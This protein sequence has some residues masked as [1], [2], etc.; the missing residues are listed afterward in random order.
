MEGGLKLVEELQGRLQVLLQSGSKNVGVRNGISSTLVELRNACKGIGE[1]EVL[2]DRLVEVGDDLWEHGCRFEAISSVYDLALELL[3]KNRVSIERELRLRL[4]CVQECRGIV[5]VRRA[6]KLLK[7]FAT[8]KNDSVRENMYFIV[9][10]LDVLMLSECA[11]LL[12]QGQSNLILQLLKNLILFT[13]SLL[14]LNQAKYMSLRQELCILFCRSWEQYGDLASAAQSIDDLE[15]RLRLLRLDESQQ[16]PIPAEVENVLINGEKLVKI[17]KVKYKLLLNSNEKALDCFK[18]ET[19]DTNQLW[20]DLEILLHLQGLHLFERSNLTLVDE[21]SIARLGEIS[22]EIRVNLLPEA[23]KQPWDSSSSVVALLFAKNG[24]WEA[25]SDIHK[26][27]PLNSRIKFLELVRKAFIL[28]SSSGEATRDLAKWMIAHQEK[29]PLV[30]DA[31]ILLW[32]KICKPILSKYLLSSIEEKN[33]LL[34]L[35]E[36]IHCS[37]ARNASAACICM[38]VEV[39]LRFS[40]V[41]SDLEQDSR[42]AI[43]ILRHAKLS[44]DVFL[45]E[46]LR[47]DP[48]FASSSSEIEK[49]KVLYIDLLICLFQ[50]ELSDAIDAEKRLVAEFKR[51]K[52]ALALLH[53]ITASKQPKEEFITMAK[54]FRKAESLLKSAESQR[55]RLKSETRMNIS[56]S[57]HCIRIEMNGEDG[58]HFRVF[59]KLAGATMSAVSKLDANLLN[60]GVLCERGEIV[61]GELDPNQLYALMIDDD[62]AVAV[63]ITVP[64]CAALSLVLCRA[65]V[66]RFLF[67]AVRPFLETSVV[68]LHHSVREQL[69]NCISLCSKACMEVMKNFLSR[70]EIQPVYSQDPWD[71]FSFKEKK[72]SISPPHLQAFVYAVLMNDSLDFKQASRLQNVNT[73]QAI[74]SLRNQK[75]LINS[76]VKLLRNSKLLVLALDA[77]Q[78][79]EDSV[80]IIQ[81]CERLFQKLVPLLRV[82]EG[83]V[84]TLR[85]LIAI[86]AALSSM[87]RDIWTKGTYELF[88]ICAFQVMRLQ[89]PSKFSLGLVASRPNLIRM[90]RSQE[91]EN[92][93]LERENF[94]TLAHINPSYHGKNQLETLQLIHE[95][96]QNPRQFLNPNEDP[97]SIG[98]DEEILFA[99]AHARVEN[100]FSAMEGAWKTIQREGMENHP[101]YLQLTS[102]LFREALAFAECPLQ[103]WIE[104]AEMLLVEKGDEKKDDWIEDV[105]LEEKSDPYQVL[106]SLKY[107]ATRE[108]DPF[109]FDRVQELDEERDNLKQIVASLSNEDETVEGLVD[110]KAKLESIERTLELIQRRKRLLANHGVRPPKE[111]VERLVT[112]SELDRLQAWR[113]YKG[114]D[115][116]NYACLYA[117]DN[118]ITL[119][120]P[121]EGRF[122]NGVLDEGP[123]TDLKWSRSQTSSTATLGP[124][125]V[126]RLFPK[127]LGSVPMEGEDVEAEESTAIENKFAANQE[128]ARTLMKQNAQALRIASRGL[129][130]ARWAHAWDQVEFCGKLLWNTLQLSWIAPSEFTDDGEAQEEEN[131]DAYDWKPIFRASCSILDM[132]EIRGEE[133]MN[134]I[135]G[136]FCDLKWAATFQIFM[137]QVFC[138][139]KRWWEILWLGERYI[140][141][142]GTISSV[143]QLFE[144]AIPLI[145]LASQNVFNDAS[146]DVESI[147]KRLDE[148]VDNW[149]KGF[150][151]K[152]RRRTTRLLRAP[153]HLPKEISQEE[154]AFIEKKLQLESEL[155]E[156]QARAF[157]T[158]EIVRKFKVIQGNLLRDRSVCEEALRKAQILARQALLEFLEPTEEGAPLRMLAEIPGLETKR[159]SLTQRSKRSPGSVASKSSKISRLSR[160]S[161][162]SQAMSIMTKQT[163]EEPDPDAEFGIQG[164]LAERALAQY[165]KAIEI[166]RQNQDRLFLSQALLEEGDFLCAQGGVAG[167]AKAVTSWNDGLDAILGNVNSIDH[168]RE[169]LPVP[170]I[171]KAPLGLEPGQEILEKLGVNGIILGTIHCA[172]LARFANLQ[173]F[174]L[175]LEHVR[176]AAWLLCGLATCTLPHPLKA[177][178]FADYEFKEL[179]RTVEYEILHSKMFQM[180]H[181]LTAMCE[182]GRLLTQ[183]FCEVDRLLALP[184]L[185]L[186]KY[187][188]EVVCRRSEIGKE[189]V[190][191]KALALIDLGLLTEASI[192]LEVGISYDASEMPQQELNMSFLESII[193]ADSCNNERKHCMARF[194][195]ESLE[196]NPSWRSGKLL[197]KMIYSLDG[198]NCNH[199]ICLLRGVILQGKAIQ[200]I[201]ISRSLLSF[202]NSVTASDMRERLFQWL[203]ARYLLAKYLTTLD[204]IEAALQQFEVLAEECDALQEFDL[205]RIALSNLAR[206]HEILGSKVRIKQKIMEEFDMLDENI[207]DLTSAQNSKDAAILVGHLEALSFFQKKTSPIPS[208]LPLMAAEACVRIEEYDKAQAILNHL[209]DE[210]MPWLIAT[211]KLGQ[212]TLQNNKTLLEEALDEAKR[213]KGGFGLDLAR[214]AAVHLAI[215]SKSE[216]E[217]VS[218]MSIAENIGMVYASRTS[219][220][221]ALASDPFG[222]NKI[223]IQT[224]NEIFEPR[225]LPRAAACVTEGDL[226][227]YV[228]KL[229]VTSRCTDT[230]D[231]N[232]ILQASEYLERKLPKFAEAFRLQETNSEKVCSLAV[233]WLE[234]RNNKFL[235]VIFDAEHRGVKTFEV[236]KDRLKDVKDVIESKLGTI[237]AA[238]SVFC[239]GKSEECVEQ[240]GEKNLDPIRNAFIAR[241]GACL[242]QVDAESFRKIVSHYY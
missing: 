64:T 231:R 221:V 158:E 87:D 86:E 43:K 128:E 19:L 85:P 216:Q 40:Q 22:E 155:D 46:T 68:H 206:L 31:A 17:W 49:V 55:L 105:L 62:N 232:F 45:S 167:W 54:L 235:M 190:A 233:Q 99:I 42:R 114:W 131:F 51:N 238:H 139:L 196:S 157:K 90:N 127:G 229:I 171:H 5:A 74:I 183:T 200:A 9:H 136:T 129:V 89:G 38:L 30:L 143:L 20:S 198:Q 225:F 3:P 4:K 220:M 144:P 187:F 201:E 44:M 208:L 176:L 184:V 164:D 69:E 170:K 236:A 13:D 97:D 175:Q 135:S 179:S 140:Q 58:K 152:Q 29:D 159:T 35:L 103:S 98:T 76:Q 109:G 26:V 95:K 72:I 63:S 163:L 1:A 125:P 50:F 71:Y 178:N 11:N 25:V 182:T 57:P 70:G 37:L 213:I 172:R 148:L 124:A 23:L 119:S 48:S 207:E 240:S 212:G 111:I 242:T 156:A 209:P 168:W 14:P 59:G 123:F 24:C 169:L 151:Q 94:Q 56:F 120:E 82:P 192:L 6:E 154:Q 41:L 214:Q 197:E 234:A 161:K 12:S 181:F 18:E 211:I 112:L 226:I 107:P 239:C 108:R 16:P 138:H 223:D 202:E 67:S 133:L 88:G 106:Q 153:A 189:M 73:K 104:R 191:Y 118:Q 219:K 224:A 116:V 193:G 162:R 149:N 130:R 146:K 186:C 150:L 113:I 230:D 21:S 222:Q 102:L 2:F 117:A 7:R 60:T 28:S 10:D 147:K 92:D 227:L 66:Q 204:Q 195:L 188:A 32:R 177:C 47:K 166:L 80:L 132:I 110:Q 33:T 83:G 142:F 100:A 185:C 96:S 194:L 77:A 141:V 27:N 241:T 205:K 121:G 52:C 199:Q 122:V 8:I 91:S 126:P 39:G 79:I 173:N 160:R 65:A 180:H 78:A 84:H 15:E 53:A 237:Q 203:Q 137:V 61:I 174:S 145:V 93:C 215:L 75:S 36:A 34:V 165:S 115:Q 101:R 81:L 210:R 134:P 228:N 218:W 217:I